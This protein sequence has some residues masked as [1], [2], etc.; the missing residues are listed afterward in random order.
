V[1]TLTAHVDNLAVVGKPTFVNHI[2]TQ[3]GQKF[4]IGTD[5]ELHHFLSIKISRDKP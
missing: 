5:E 3:I 2:I 4:K 1:G